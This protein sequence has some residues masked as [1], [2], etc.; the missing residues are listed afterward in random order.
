M[1]TESRREAFERVQPFLY[2]ESEGSGA[3][4]RFWHARGIEAGFNAALD[5]VAAPDGSTVLAKSCAVEV[6]PDCDIMGC[7]HIRDRTGAFAPVP[8]EQ[9][10]E[11]K[12]KL[13]NAENTIHQT[14]L[15]LSAAKRRIEILTAEPQQEVVESVY[16]AVDSALRHHKM[17]YQFYGEQGL[18][19]V[20][21][22]SPNEDD[23]IERGE[24]ELE[25]II[26]CAA[27]A[28][29]SALPQQR[30]WKRE[31]LVALF[32]KATH[33]VANPKLVYQQVDALITA[34]AVKVES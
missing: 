23:S 17:K 18:P 29:L 1:T 10:V 26:E 6:C 20:D 24:E 33:G 15:Q 30:V 9:V 19:L 3:V 32:M 5:S 2:A 8:Q 21:A 16:D 4:A 25:A 34:N 7:Q 22:V 12:R 27:E 14:R 28:A 13:A 31:E 11:L